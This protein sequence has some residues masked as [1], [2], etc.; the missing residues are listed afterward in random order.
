MKN[1]QHIHVMLEELIRE[2]FNVFLEIHH[3]RFSPPVKNYRNKFIIARTTVAAYKSKEDAIMAH[4][5]K[6]SVM[7]IITTVSECSIGDQFIKKV[8]LAKALHR[9][10]RELSATKKIAVE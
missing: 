2:K 9:M 4:K 8:G 5:N 7:P 3:D 1:K 10:Y 6:G